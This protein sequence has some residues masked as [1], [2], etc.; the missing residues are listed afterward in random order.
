MKRNKNEKVKFADL[1]RKQKILKI[2]KTA[3][4]VLGGIVAFLCIVVAVVAIVIRVH[5]GVW[6]F[7][8]MTPDNFKAGV[9]MLTKDRT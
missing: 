8:F 5:F 4:I 7:K 6:I 9:A 2:A 3:G 1:T